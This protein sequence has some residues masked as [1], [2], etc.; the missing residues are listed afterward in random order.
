MTP[1]SFKDWTIDCGCEPC[2]RVGVVLPSDDM[3]QLRAEVPAQPYDLVVDGQRVGRVPAGNVELS[4]QAGRVRFADAGQTRAAGSVVRLVPIDPPAS[5]QGSGVR[6]CDVV[7]GRGFHWQKRVTF[8]LEGC[9]EFRAFDGRLLGVNELGLEEY[10]QCVITSEMSGCCPLEFLK[11]QCVV[12]RSWVLAHTEQ[13]HTEWPVDR[14]N[15]DCCQRYHGTSYL[16][17]QAVEAV[18]A[19]RGQVVADASGR[20]IDANYS[21]SCGGIIE[22]PEHVWFTSKPGQRAAADAPADSAA[23]RFM[24]VTDANFDEFLT[25]AWLADTDVFCSPTVVPDAELPQYLGSVD[26]GGGHF[27]WRVEYTRTELEELLQRKL[28]QVFASDA[29]VPKQPVLVA[30]VPP[31]VVHVRVPRIGQL[32][33]LRVLE[34]GPSGR[35]SSLQIDYVSSDGQTCSILIRSE[36]RIREALYDKFLFSSAF[37][38]EME[39]DSSGVPM[40]IRLLGAGWGHGAGLCQIGALGMAVKGYACRDILRH[41]FEGVDL[42]SLYPAMA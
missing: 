24:P 12:A 14:C 40:T 17:P 31:A 38:V 35:A 34:R 9:L 23:R 5:T 29:P 25:G 18:V 13:K 42:R 15:D 30:D 20:I 11:S 28:G 8:S 3:R 21:K 16:T 19:T 4:V 10:L 33:D 26:E 39:R 41:Y 32:H 22:A 37:K 2:I 1:C 7:T 6:L 27:R 36:Y